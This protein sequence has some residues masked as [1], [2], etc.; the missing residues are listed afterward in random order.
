MSKLKFSAIFGLALL[1]SGTAHAQT[2]TDCSGTITSG[3]V[4]Q[5]LSV[6]AA[7]TTLGF[8]VA[9]DSTTEPLCLSFTGTASCGAPATY[10]LDPASPTS[11]NSFSTPSWWTASNTGFCCCLPR[12][13]MCFTARTSQR[14]LPRPPR[15][16]I[17]L[18]WARA[19]HCRAAI[20]SQPRAIPE[21]PHT[22]LRAP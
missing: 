9:H 20:W 18:I 11:M 17:H 1:C 4:A 12:R 22:P 13:G 2:E 19:M 3:G 5:N 6:P 14:H 10:T 15:R 16:S 21:R 8:M 7:S